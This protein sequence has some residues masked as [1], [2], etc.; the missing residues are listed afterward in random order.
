MK[1]FVLGLTGGIASGK[2]VVTSFFREYGA[3]V[4]DADVVSR[5]IMSD[6]AIIKRIEQAFPGSV[7]DGSI[8]RAELKKAAF[9]SP[10]NTAKLNGITH[11]PI[12]EL[13]RKKIDAAGGFVLFVVPL[14]FETGLDC[15]CDA[16]AVVVC[17]RE[18][19]IKRLIARDNIDKTI[20][21]NIMARQMDDQTRE[22]KADYVIRNDGDEKDLKEN[23]VRLMKRLGIIEQ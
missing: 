9:I 3:T 19:R 8:N 23:A 4:V 20:A 16:T 7:E 18:K 5:E 10:E 2:S 21:E 13:C 6:P 17:D 11:P 22:K 12:R 14:L 1:K 15:F